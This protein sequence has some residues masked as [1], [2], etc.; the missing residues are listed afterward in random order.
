MSITISDRQVPVDR[1]AELVQELLDAHCDTVCLA[2][3][4]DS[5]PD[6]GPHLDYLRDLQCVGKRMLA[7]LV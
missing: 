4:L 1:L 6:W 2:G 5:E 7:E 3:R